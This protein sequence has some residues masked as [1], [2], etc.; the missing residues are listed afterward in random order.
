MS[1]NGSAR[2]GTAEAQRIAYNGTIFRCVTGSLL[3]GL[4]DGSGDRDETGI[5]VE[6]PEYV[7]GLKR[8][9]LPDTG[10]RVAFEQYIYR[11]QPDGVRSGPGDLD[12]T[13]YSLRKFMQLVLDGN[14]A[15]LQLLFI[16]PEYVI[17]TSALW[18]QMQAFT[19]LFLS[20]LAGNRFI[21][22]M[23]KQ[24]ASMLSRDGKGR[25]VTRP[26][27]VERYGWDVKYGSHLIRVGCQ[28]AELVGTGRLT[29]PM[30][31]RQRE[32]V[33]SIRAGR[34][35]MQQVL[36]L[37]ESQEEEI[38]ART[39]GSPLPEQPDCYAADRWL[40]SAYQQAWSCS[41]CCAGR[42]LTGT[43]GRSCCSRSRGGTRYLTLSIACRPCCLV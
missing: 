37:S 41:L 7:I 2:H 6:P 43:A 16:P 9:V 14:P 23:Q 21:G 36:D 12:Y 1:L 29:L 32:L 24:R 15:A 3:H 5:C 42:T 38:K 17:M 30:P 10:H 4:S 28:G 20:R 25:N 39:A 11:S 40:V 18:E 13:C 27:L 33:R 26:E 34:L 35:T 8:I 31:A 22:Y 19:G